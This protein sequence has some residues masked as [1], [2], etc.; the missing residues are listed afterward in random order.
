MTQSSGYD[1]HNMDPFFRDVG[2]LRTKFL[3]LEYK[4]RT[5]LFKKSG[6]PF[7]QDFDTI[8][9]GDFVDENPFTNWDTLGTL[10]DKYNAI[11]ESNQSLVID[12][13]I[14]RIRDALAHGRIYRRSVESQPRLLKFS[15][16]N[17][18]T[19]KVQTEFAETLDPPTIGKWNL[20]MFMTIRKVE[21]AQRS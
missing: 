18:T 14:V 11:V 10:I 9:E 17:K 12:R 8:S 19:G 7:M 1:F 21:D 5:F 4:L 15:Q 6:M 2:D 13:S 16:V 3:I 20:F